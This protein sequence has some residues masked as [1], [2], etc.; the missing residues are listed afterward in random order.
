M[1]RFPQSDSDYF[2]AYAYDTLWSLAHFYQQQFAHNQS[3]T[4]RFRE[5]ID[6]IDFLGATVSKIDT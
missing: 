5:A 2:D 3:N 4:D 6:N 1:K